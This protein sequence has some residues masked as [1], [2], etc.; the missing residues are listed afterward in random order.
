MNIQR[1]AAVLGLGAAA[2]A[3]GAVAVEAAQ[4][5]S[6][7]T[8]ADRR[9]VEAVEEVARHVR[10]ART[11]EDPAILRTIREAQTAFLRA[12]QRFP[13]FIEI[14]TGVWEQHWDWHVHTGQQP[15]IGQVSDGRYGMT[16]FLTTLVL[17][18]G[19]TPAYVGP[20]SA[21]L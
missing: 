3:V 1:R 14:G 2:A 16:V 5:T 13:T 12:N 7:P 20:G 10:A 15:V 18:P 4:R 9:L 8:D 17:H 11:Q 6:T 19:A 21:S